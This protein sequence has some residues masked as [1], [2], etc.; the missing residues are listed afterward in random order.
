[1]ARSGFQT[2][3]WSKKSET[4][5]NPPRKLTDGYVFKRDGGMPVLL[6]PVLNRRDKPAR[7]GVSV[8]KAD[9]PAI[10]FAITGRWL[11]GPAGVARKMAST[12]AIDACDKARVCGPYGVGS[13]G[14][15]V[16]AFVWS[17]RSQAGCNAARS[18]TNADS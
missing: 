17:C 15:D 13:R 7:P 1:M 16:F 3:R 11:W 12:P 2:A 10:T 18:P 6:S 8:S 14:F 5:K 9:T 4:V